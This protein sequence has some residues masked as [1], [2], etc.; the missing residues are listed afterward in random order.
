MY[1]TENTKAPSVDAN[2]RKTKLCFTLFLNIFSQPLPFL[3]P[4]TSDNPVMS[5]HG[6]LDDIL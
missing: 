5:V 3:V 4:Q 2:Y 6:S 1:G